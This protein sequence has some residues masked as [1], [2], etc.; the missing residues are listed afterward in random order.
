PPL[1]KA[2]WKGKPVDGIWR[3][4]ESHSVDLLLSRK[5]ER[6]DPERQTAVDDRGDEY[7]YDQ[8]LLATGG[9]PRR[10]PFGGGD[11]LYYRT[12]TDFRRL[13]AQAERGQRFVVIGGGFIGAEIAAALAM[14]G[15]QVTLIFPEAT[16]GA[17][18]FP[19][20]L[21]R[22][23][24]DYYREKG[25]TV[26]S[27]TFVT[28]AEG[29]DT[30]VLV[31]TS[32]RELTADMVVAGIGIQPNVELAQSAG[33]AVEDG[34][35]VDELLR[36]TRPRIF[37]AGDVAAFYIA[38]LDKRLRF[39]HEDNALSMGRQAGRNMAGAQAAYL[40]LPFFYSDLFD[41]GYE[42][43]GEVDSRLETLVDWKQPFREGVV[44]YHAGGVVRG[45]LLWNVWNQVATARRLIMTRQL[46]RPGL[47]QSQ[48]AA[49]A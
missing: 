11:I 31:Q 49:T 36:T 20:D 35:V 37:A 18:V 29:R 40:H 23:L 3:H 12:V 5:V 16:L 13:H 46:A 26:L 17:R 2:L 42:A 34:I 6:V 38:A 24:N 10:L 21:G 14:N 7:S 33:L 44:Y 27:H 19:D 48:A 25:V 8:M 9:R 28:G 41:L 1:S 22:F 30:H 47:L 15:K 45:V 4:T 32:D 39:E 43:V